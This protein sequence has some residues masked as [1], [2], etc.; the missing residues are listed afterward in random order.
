MFLYKHAGPDGSVTNSNV[1]LVLVP[2]DRNPPDIQGLEVENWANSTN[3]IISWNPDA[4]NASHVDIEISQFDSFEFR[5]H[6]LQ[7]GLISF[8]HVEN[9]GSYNLDYSEENVVPR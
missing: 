4:I 2:M 1:L 6:Q 3:T 9:S 8:K 5:L 7:G